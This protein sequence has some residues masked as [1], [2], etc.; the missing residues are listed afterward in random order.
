[1]NEFK[2]YIL[3][4]ILLLLSILIYEAYK[5]VG[6]EYSNAFEITTIKDSQYN[7]PKL[8]NSSLFVITPNNSTIIFYKNFYNLF[9]SLFISSIKSAELTPKNNTAYSM[10]LGNQ[11]C[12]TPLADGNITFY[13]NPLNHTLTTF[14][15]NQSVKNYAIKSFYTALHSV[16]SSGNSQII[17][18]YNE[19]PSIS[20]ITFIYNNS[21]NFY[22]PFKISCKSLSG[23]SYIYLFDDY[24]NKTISSNGTATLNIWAYPNLTVTCYD[25]EQMITKS[26]NFTKITPILNLIYRNNEVYCN[27]TVDSEIYLKIGNEQVIGTGSVSYNGSNIHGVITCIQPGNPYQEEETKSI[28]IA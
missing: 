11:T 16:S 22:K 17:I 20:K 2:I 7:I 4:S 28:N 10:V 5:P 13:F 19:V 15:F 8:D 9:L 25:G 23:K 24:G 3:V 27:S 12:Y 6:T 26:I 21:V 1:M 14:C 18:A